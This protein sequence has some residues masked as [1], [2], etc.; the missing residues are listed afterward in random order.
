MRGE[1][2]I[3]RKDRTAVA[4]TETHAPGRNNFD[5]E[6]AELRIEHADAELA[7]GAGVPGVVVLG[8][9]RK[10]A[11]TSGVSTTKRI[12]HDHL[13]VLI[14]FASDIAHAQSPLVNVG[15]KS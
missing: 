2:R 5:E 3:F 11:T 8:T 1:G 14:D 9:K 13:V 15:R 6:L 4:A 12:V 7:R 10:M